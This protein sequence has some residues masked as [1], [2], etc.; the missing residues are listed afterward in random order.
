MILT[1]FSHMLKNLCAAEC[2][3][4]NIQN[5]LK[6]PETEFRHARDYG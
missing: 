3:M 5:L 4:N 2:G 1:Y 6:G